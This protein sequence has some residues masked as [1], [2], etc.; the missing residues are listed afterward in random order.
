MIIRR[1]G[2]PEVLETTEEEAPKPGRGEVRVLAAGFL[3]LL[4]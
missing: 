3:S 1:H 2:G 4:G